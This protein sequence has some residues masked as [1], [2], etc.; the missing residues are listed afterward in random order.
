[1]LR[2]YLK[3]AWRNLFRSK[4][5]AF[6]TIGGLG[7]GMAMAGL[8]C[9]WVYNEFNFDTYHEKADRIYRI[10]SQIEVNEGDLW[11]WS[12]TPYSLGQNLEDQVDEI[13]G[14]T[15]V[16][17]PWRST[18]LKANEATFY[19]DKLGFVKGNWFDFFDYKVLAGSLEDFKNERQGLVLTASA[20]R[21][22][23]GQTDV[24]GRQIELD[25][26]TLPVKAVIQ[27]NPTNSSFTYQVFARNE[28]R[29][30]NEANRSQDDGWGNFNFVT[31]VLLREN[32]D[33]AKVAEK[34]TNLFRKWKE[35]KSGSNT[36]FFRL[37]SELH[38]D[39]ETVDGT[40][41]PP[42]DKKTLY[43]FGG[44]ALFILLIACVNYIN[45]TTARTT[46]RFKEVSVKKMNGA[47]QS[48]LFGQFM[49]ESLLNSLLA[50]LLAIVLISLSMSAFNNLTEQ[51]FSLFANP[52]LWYI[53]IGIT[54]FTFTVSGIYP[55][56]VLSSGNP[57]M[58]LKG[59]LSKI[60][61]GEGFR[62]GLVVFQ[63]SFSLILVICTFVI[64]SQMR[65]IQKM[66]L[67]YNKEQ[68]FTFQLPFEERRLNPNLPELIADELSKESYVSE[69]TL[70]TA[71]IVSIAQR[72]SGNLTWA[73]KDDNW[74]PVLTPLGVSDNY[75]EFFD[76]KMVAGRWYDPEST[77]D[78]F[79]LILNENA[80]KNLN[81][82]EPVLG[83]TLEYQGESGQVIGIVKDF[84]FGNVHEA[85]SPVVIHHPEEWNWLNTVNVRATPENM[86]K[87]IAAAGQ[88][89]TTK[90]PKV[91]FKYDFLDDK[92][93]S[94]HE[95]EQRQ[96]SLF[97]IFG[98]VVLLI[99]CVGLFGLAAFSVETRVKE[100]GIR[101]VLGSGVAGILAL[102]SKDFLKLI[103]LS[104]I[105][106]IPVAWWFMHKWLEDFAYHINLSWHLLVIPVVAILVIAVITVS[107]HTLRAALMNPVKSL[108]SE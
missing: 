63:F 34:T 67:G 64:Y 55:S 78:K 97:N 28:L 93:A 68:V 17:N 7:L 56:V 60:H 58:M 71:G 40:T 77:A 41:V 70:S 57:L 44:I 104:A 65:Y 62:K 76:L 6:I 92:F 106:G 14:I 46:L 8:L 22:Y 72:N 23:F 75:K 84:N 94:M 19:E 43:I 91:P 37:L 15:Q 83:S 29:R 25:S 13:E 26:L 80:V 33:A 87:A 45:L 99:S 59:R 24:V 96:L 3:I 66:D 9:L 82:P 49:T 47:S 86:S 74:N 42:V 53:L 21:K 85:I 10:N 18:P 54:L 79:N 20:A 30:E 100:I 89:W 4:L 5:Y 36:L 102:L 101:K 11:H 1:M 105:P 73:G 98:G 107:F 95:A 35:D 108:R 61:R 90:I 16:Y 32:A 69:V 2:N 81:I 12:V 50:A 88:W 51:S 48:S 52:V 31:Y 39:T 27:D 103:L 38:F